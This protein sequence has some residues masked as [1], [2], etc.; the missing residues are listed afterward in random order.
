MGA[1]W[2][3]FEKV[4]TSLRR[5]DGETFPAAATRKPFSAYGALPRRGNLLTWKRFPDGCDVETLFDVETFSTLPRGRRGNLF[6]PAQRFRRR[7]RAHQKVSPSHPPGEGDRPQRDGKIIF[8]ARA[9]WKPFASFFAKG[10]LV[11]VIDVAGK[12]RCSARNQADVETFPYKQ[13]GFPVD[14]MKKGF[15]VV[16]TFTWGEACSEKVSPSP[17]RGQ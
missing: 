4:S 1:T 2:E 3:P 13:K 16:A 12:C 5:S 7:S 8:Y 9:T 17:R 14:M 10:F 6:M 11:G 15:Y